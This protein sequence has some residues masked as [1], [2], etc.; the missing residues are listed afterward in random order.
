MKIKLV[1]TAFILA[2]IGAINWGTVGVLGI[3]LVEVLFGFSPLLVKS[4]YTLVGLSGLYLLVVGRGFINF[5][6]SKML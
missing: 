4:V 6:G 5:L 2:V 1:I 3:N